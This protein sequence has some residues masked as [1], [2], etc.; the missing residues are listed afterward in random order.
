MSACICVFIPLFFVLLF[1]SPVFSPPSSFLLHKPQGHGAVSLD[2]VIIFEQNDFVLA[3]LGWA[4]HLT[5]AL[6]LTV[7]EAI[8]KDIYDMGFMLLQMFYNVSQDDRSDF[9]AFSTLAQTSYETFCE[10]I[11]RLEVPVRIRNCIMESMNP[12]PSRRPSLPDIVRLLD[13]A[14][15]AEKEIVATRRRLS[16]AG[17]KMDGELIDKLFP[18]RVARAL[19]AGR[20]VE[21]MMHQDLTLLF[22][23]IV[24]FTELSSKLD[25]RDVQETLNGLFAAFDQVVRK[26]ECFKLEII[27][28]PL[29][30]A[31]PNQCTRMASVL[32]GWAELYIV[33]TRSI[34]NRFH[35]F[36]S[37]YKTN[38]GTHIWSWVVFWTT[39]PRTT[40]AALRALPWRWSRSSSNSSLQNATSSHVRSCHG[41]RT[42]RCTVLSPP[43]RPTP[44]PVGTLLSPTHP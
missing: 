32:K 9:E 17:N 18:P 11:N 12:V 5:D 14:V 24:G 31:V 15:D 28:S 43:P 4:A 16:I 20:K 37:I 27:V 21:P 3:K 33:Y 19:R 29:R 10:T 23:D 36:L 2:S 22:S 35:Y 8:A 7:E 38:R 25:S 42:R 44:L 13:R 41:T 26:H 34:L 40:Q 6:K 39:S 30:N 1:P